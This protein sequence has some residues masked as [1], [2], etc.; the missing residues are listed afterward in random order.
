MKCSF[1]GAKVPEGR[2]KIFVKTTGQ[3][4][5]FCN[6]KCQ[7]NWNKGREGKHTKWTQRAR[8]ERAK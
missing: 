2:G 5:Q 6:S 7:K 1:C 4:F 3:A 8:E